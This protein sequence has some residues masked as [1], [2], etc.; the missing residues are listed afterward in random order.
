MDMVISAGKSRKNVDAYIL[1][2]LT[3]AMQWTCLFRP[4]QLSVC[5]TQI[6][7]CLLAC[8]PTRHSVG[9][10]NYRKSS[11]NVPVWNV[12]SV[13]HQLYYANISLPYRRYVISSLKHIIN[14][15]VLQHSYLL[16]CILRAGKKMTEIMKTDAVE[17]RSNPKHGET[18]V[19]FGGCWTLTL[20][21]RERE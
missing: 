4:D 16:C 21:E 6:R 18:C 8:P 11:G 5:Q 12:P 20:I 10:L 9:M 7:M 14:F 19:P 13:S 17:T 15:P 1:L 3:P 2:H